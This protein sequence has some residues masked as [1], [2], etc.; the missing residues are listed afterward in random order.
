[1]ASL[2]QAVA[3]EDALGY[4]E[5]PGWLIPVRHALGAA[6]L[7][8]GRLVEA[9]AAYREDLERHPNNGWA[10][11]GLA[12]TLALEGRSAESRADDARF[13]AVWARADVTIDASC[14]CQSSLAGVPDGR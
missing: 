7:Q 9:E 4:D 14:L 11:Y 1:L 8:R 6:L 3:L 13:R 12:R 2:R 10:L 5:P